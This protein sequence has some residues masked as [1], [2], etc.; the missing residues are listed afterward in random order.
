VTQK[1]GYT[2]DFLPTIKTL[3]ALLAAP[4]ARTLIHNGITREVF[5]KDGFKVTMLYKNVEQYTAKVVIPLTEIR[6]LETWNLLTDA[7]GLILTD[8]SG[9]PFTE[10]LKMS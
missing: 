6:V 8:A 9:V 5:A 2:F 3:M 4:N 7:S 1:S 10:I